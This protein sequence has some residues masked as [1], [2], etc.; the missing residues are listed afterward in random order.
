MDE[1]EDGFQFAPNQRQNSVQKAGF[2]FSLVFGIAL[3]PIGIA[4]IVVLAAKQ[5]NPIFGILAVAAGV[6]LTFG[7]RSVNRDQ[8]RR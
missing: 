8:K 2:N 4:F 6:L 3:V 1:D 7:A 5:E